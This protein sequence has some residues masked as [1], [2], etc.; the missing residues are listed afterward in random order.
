MAIP[1]PPGGPQ[2]Q[3][4]LQNPARFPD[5]RLQ[6]YAQGQQP[7]GQVP[8]PM[9]ANEL[10]I[11]NAQRQAASRQS[12]MQNNPQN[13][14]TVFQQKDM[15]LQQKAQQLAAMQ[16]QMQQQM[17]QREQQTQQ[18]EQQLGV[19]GALM[20]KKA[21][22]LQAR[23]AMGVAQLPVN[24][25]MFTAMHG[26]IVFSGGGRVPGYAS[27]GLVADEDFR[28]ANAEPQ[29]LSEEVLPELDPLQ[30]RI[31]EM[32]AARE[33]RL[34]GLRSAMLS[35]QEKEELERKERE[36]LEEQY[37]RY[38]EGIGGLDEETAAAI[39]GKPTSMLQK[40]AAGLPTD[41]R[42]MRLGTGIASIAKGYM[43]EVAKE[44]S[45][46]REAAKY[47]ADAKRKQAAADLAEQRNQDTLARQLR[48]AEQSDRLK[49]DELLGRD[50]VSELEMLKGVAG[51]EESQRS[52]QE[53]K[54][55]AEDR[56]A[57]EKQK[58]ASEEAYRAGDRAFREKMVRL[59]ASLRPEDFSNRL[60]RMATNP[61]DPNQE[62]ARNLLEN[63]GR[64]GAGA[65][66]RPT[67]DQ[68]YD[69]ALKRFQGMD[70][71]KIIKKAANDP[72]NPRTLTENDVFSMV[73]DE[74]FERVKQRFGDSSLKGQGGRGATPTSGASGTVD[75]NNPLLKP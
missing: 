63:R 7:T 41:T 25:D 75:M 61:N 15:E 6:Q 28:M 3:A 74:E 14:P 40:L 45:R 10:T 43:G 2:V 48:A 56:M 47:I 68:V 71:N 16:Q 5:Q 33:R 23:E 35:P 57:F 18:K 65:D 17:Q 29:L 32:K 13:S 34:V 26:G 59:E 69:N 44:E 36:R 72:K 31:A 1:F 12:A 9:A 11:R 55:A 64:G 73:L 21:Q 70:V 39:R 27:R 66:G 50:V 24:P 54:K 38:K 37:K 4:A 58:F 62:Y 20:A 22:D 67:Y 53:S 8:P 52:R 46:E 60:L 42:G 30:K 51:L 49:A 19:I